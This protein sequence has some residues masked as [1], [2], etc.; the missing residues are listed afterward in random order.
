MVAVNFLRG[1]AVLTVVVL[2]GFIVL[3]LRRERKARGA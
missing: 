2:G 1:G 3:M